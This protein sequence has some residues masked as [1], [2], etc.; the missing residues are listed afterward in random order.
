MLPLTQR[1]LHSLDASVL[2]MASMRDSKFPG[3]MRRLT[4]PLPYKLLSEPFPIQTRGE[5]LEQSEKLAFEALTCAKEE[6]V[7]SYASIATG[8]GNSAKTESVSRVF[9]PI[10]E[11]SSKTASA[12]SSGSE[13]APDKNTS[14]KEPAD[15]HDR[16]QCDIPLT[17]RS[18]IKSIKYEPSH[19]SYTQIAEYL[20]C[21]HRYF[22]GRVMKLPSEPS[23]AMM[24]GRALHEA[25]ASFASDLQEHKKSI[26]DQGAAHA[27]EEVIEEARERAQ[28][29]FVQAWESEGMFVSSEQEQYLFEQGQQALAVFCSQHTDRNILHVEHPFEVFVP[30]ANVQLRGVW[31][32]ID[33]T[34]NGPIIKEFKSNMS[35]SERNVRKLAAESLQLKLYMYAF[36]SVFG[37]AP[38]GAILE[39]IGDESNSVRQGQDQ[40]GYVPFTPEAASEALE[41]IQSVVAGLREG[42]FTPKPSYME[43][44]FC[45]FA[46]SVCR[47][48]SEAA[49]V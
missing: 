33:H 29:I 44:A 17:D 4:M 43:C 3:R 19:L 27:G 15:H 10:W 16:D 2:F 39:M 48:G 1:N 22:L 41:T 23:A 5:F 18:A 37:S 26:H 46:S 12:S 32:R 20:R 38:R 34:A 42:D 45:P 11:E 28:D 47:V 40:Q 9:L 21:P 8:S 36:Q 24:Y 6:V 31:D 25:V 7:I 13:S 30:E 14:A 49:R 35:G